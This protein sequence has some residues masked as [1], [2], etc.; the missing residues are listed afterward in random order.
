MAKQEVSP[1][2][3]KTNFLYSILFVNA[4]RLFFLAAS[5]VN[6]K[7]RRGFVGRRKLFHDLEKK[8]EKIPHGKRVWFHASSLGEFEQAKPIIELMKE[9]GYK[10]VVTF[11]SPSGHDYS[12][13]YP[14]ADVVTYI[15]FD[16]KK[17]A[18]RFVE[19]V[20]PAAV[21][22]MRYDLWLNHLV[23]AR[24]HGAKVML[25]DATFPT[26][27]LR[28]SAFIKEFFR[29]LYQCCDAILTT[30]IEHRKMFDS[31]IGEGKAEVAGDTRYDRVHARSVTN[32][33]LEKLPLRIDRSRRTVV[34]MGST[35]P[36]DIDVLTGALKKLTEEYPELLILIVPHEPTS[37]EVRKLSAAFT[38][39]MILSELDGTTEGFSFL[40]VDRVGLLTQLYVLGD[41]AYVGGGFGSGVHNVL[42]P[43]VYGIPIIT[44]PRIERSDEAVALMKEGALF[45]VKDS[46]D[47]YEILRRMIS[48]RSAREKAG[49]TAKNFV[50]RHLGASIFV[51]D[52]IKLMCGGSPQ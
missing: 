35:W 51:A 20:S 19:L 22:V 46:E 25:A 48:D 7:A 15:P 31:F 49:T 17:N 2:S 9:S 23:E 11:F 38:G 36:Q 26:K 44:G 6:G 1:V 12:L 42:E 30:T 21:I 3:G 10:T 33:V 27:L 47:S 34:V 4:M 18:R 32:S 50:D 43:A 16:T 28:R 8:L 24:K 52:K 5:L 40:I 45:Y 39:T 37:D 13:N 14:F 29:E 41:I